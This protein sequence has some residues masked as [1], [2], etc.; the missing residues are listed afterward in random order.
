MVI[1]K[2]PAPPSTGNDLADTVIKA[3]L[4]VGAVALIKVILRK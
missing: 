1:V 2:T 4:A 3:A